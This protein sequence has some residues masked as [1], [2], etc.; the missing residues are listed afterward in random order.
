VITRKMGFVA[1]AALAVGLALG[2]GGSAL[3]ADPTASPDFD[4]MMGGHG[5][6]GGQGMMGGLTQEHRQQTLQWCDQMH[7][8]LHDSL[9]ASPSPSTGP[10]SR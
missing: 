7:D 3:A 2:F 1:G 8:G 6:M 9:S 4:S 5:M 10:V